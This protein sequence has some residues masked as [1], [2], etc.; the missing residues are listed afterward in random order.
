MWQELDKPVFQN[1]ILHMTHYDH[2][3]EIDSCQKRNEVTG[4]HECEHYNRM[5][6]QQYSEQLFQSDV[7]HCALVNHP[8]RQK[9]KDEVPSLEQISQIQ[10]RHQANTQVYSSSPYSMK[11][12]LMQMLSSL[13]ENHIM[14]T[15]KRTQRTDKYLGDI[16][17]ELNLQFKKLSYE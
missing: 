2:A 11:N 9:K 12:L 3:I 7:L 10:S 6:N 8:M 17:N 16:Y 15:Y 13:K 14:K 5:V 4:K 1:Q